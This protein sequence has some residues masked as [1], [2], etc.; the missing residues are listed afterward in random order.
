MRRAFA[1][2]LVLGMISAA[3]AASIADRATSAPGAE[4]WRTAVLRDVV[5]GEEFAIKDLE[6][7]VVAIETMAIWC[8][9]CRLQQGEAQAAL[10]EVASR[11]V[12]YISLDVDPNERASDLAEYAR[13]QGYGW[14]FVVASR[15]VARSLAT[16]FGDQILSPPSTPLLVLGP[17]GALIEK[18]LGVKSA[19]ELAGLFREHLP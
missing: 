4:G 16:T 6:G 14:R 1:T 3:C 13:R 10:A 8:V 5:T 7:K 18:H 2:V 9:N 11:D 17:D 19:D 15:E 12:V